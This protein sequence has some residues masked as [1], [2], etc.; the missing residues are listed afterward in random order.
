MKTGFY[1]QGKQIIE[2]K[3]FLMQNITTET[4]DEQA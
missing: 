3:Q 1:R 2:K 4:Q